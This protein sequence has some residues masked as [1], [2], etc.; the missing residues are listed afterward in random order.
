MSWL[1][2]QL[3]TLSLIGTPAGVGGAACR[4]K[5]G[6]AKKSKTE[7]LALLATEESLSRN[8]SHTIFLPSEPLAHR[9][10]QDL[11]KF[12]TPP[13]GRFIAGVPR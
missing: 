7:N 11:S 6:E 1:S 8:P 2:A 9:P 4:E 13:Y 12:F 3:R 10:R 5:A